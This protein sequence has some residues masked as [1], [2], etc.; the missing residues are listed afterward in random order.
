MT[1]KHTNDSK[2]GNKEQ[3]I[4]DYLAYV[5]SKY[6][7]ILIEKDIRLVVFRSVGNV[8]ENWKVFNR[9]KLLV[10]R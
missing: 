5:E 7:N 4:L 6:I 2:I 8:R 10:L 1:S 3:Q 9:Y